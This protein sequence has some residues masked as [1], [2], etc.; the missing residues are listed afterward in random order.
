MGWSLK[1]FVL[2][3]NNCLKR[4]ESWKFSNCLNDDYFSFQMWVSLGFSCNGQFSREREINFEPQN[5]CKQCGFSEFPL[6]GSTWTWNLELMNNIYFLYLF[7]LFIYYS[8]MY[9]CNLSATICMTAFPSHI[10][11]SILTRLVHVG[12]EALK[13]QTQHSGK[14]IRSYWHI[15]L[16]HWL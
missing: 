2:Q 16:N 9:F 7:S 4:T 12:T 8:F 6:W 13:M 11:M 3:Q 14:R 5:S 1:S 15:C 10:I